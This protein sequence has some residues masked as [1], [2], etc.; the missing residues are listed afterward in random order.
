MATYK[1]NV[2]KLNLRSGPVQDFANKENVIGVLR[3][4]A[5]FECVRVIENEL[6][7]WCVGEDGH[8][9]SEKWLEGS[10]SPIIPTTFIPKGEKNSDWM[11]LLG[12]AEV[13]KI[14]KGKS[15]CVAVLDSGVDLNNT[16]ITSQLYQYGSDF[17]IDDINV[18]KNLINS[19]SD[20][21]D[22]FGHGTHCT[23]LISCKNSKNIVAVAPET[24]LF[25]GKIYNGGLDDF[26]Q[27]S[28]GI[29][30]ASNINEVDIISV[31]NGLSDA[32]KEDPTLPTLKSALDFALSKNK[33]VIASIGNKGTDQNPLYP[34]LF[35]ECISTGAIESNGSYYEGNVD[36][37]L[38]KIYAPGVS[39]FSNSKNG[40]FISLTGTSQS[41][42]I[43]AGII[44]LIISHLKSKNLQYSKKSI[45]EIITIYSRDIINKQNKK[46]ID[47]LNIFSHI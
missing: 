1:V 7:R 35:N 25:I 42:A 14:T 36:S 27:I 39:I 17:K 3:K 40:E 20:V 8:C 15:V 9:V 44:A 22:V 43:V 31:S 4:D 28:K 33:I 6:G 47:P 34:G 24:K 11:N 10:L 13:W 23:S 46:Y 41:T 5:V 16:D 37:P 29:I 18:C 30:W 19:T 21:N 45:E 12:I 38:T 26:N 32:N 2:D